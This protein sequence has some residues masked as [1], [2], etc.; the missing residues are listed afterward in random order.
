MKR[1]RLLVKNGGGRGVAWHLRGI[2]D[3]R[4]YGEIRFDIPR[5]KRFNIKLVQNTFQEKHWLQICS[6]IDKLEKG[7]SHLLTNTIY[8]SSLHAFT[9]GKPLSF[10]AGYFPGDEEKTETGKTYRQLLLIL[11]EYL[12]PYY[13]NVV[14]KGEEVAT[15][16]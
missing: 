5:E 15:A 3:G 8:W 10:V 4:F 6:L 7:E 16:L 2:Q 14:P 1:Y 11:E 13:V 9:K 12:K